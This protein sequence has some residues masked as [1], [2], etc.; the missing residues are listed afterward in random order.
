MPAS[1]HETLSMRCAFLQPL[2]AI[3]CTVFLGACAATTPGNPTPM[4]SDS[5]SP[6]PPVAA[7]KP[8]PVP[9]PN[10]SREDEYYWLRDD[11]R[12]DPEVLAYL[13]AENAY[14]DAMLAHV[15][16]LQ[17]KLYAEI[18]ARIKQDDSSVP[19]RK[20][21]YWYYRR[22]E[23]GRE[24]PLYAR[25]QGSPD[26]PEQV[27][28]DANALA[29]GHEFFAV[30]AL[31]VSPDDRYVAWAEDTVGRRQYVLRIKDLVTGEI[32][33]DRIGNTDG[34]I[35]WT[36]DGAS[37]LYIEKD[38]QTLLGWRVRRHVLGS[39]PA[40]DPLVYEQEDLSFYTGLTTTKDDRYILIVS[41][42]TLTSEV[43]FAAAADPA[44]AFRVMIPREK[45]HEYDVDHLDGRWVIRSNWEAPNFRLLEAPDGEQGDRTRWREIIGHRDDA[46]I[47][48]FDVFRDFVAVNERSEGLRKLRILGW[49]GRTDFHVASDEP[50]YAMTLGTNE[51]VETSV[52]RYVYASLTTPA[53]TYDF[54]VATGERRLMKREPV[55]GDFDPANYATEYRWATARDGTRVPVSIVY[56]RT[57]R[58]D[59][60][61]PLVVY[62]YGAYGYALD[63][64]FSLT[65]LPLLDRGFVYAIAH[66]RGGQ[67]LGR[68]WYDAGRLLA[69]KNTFTD[70]VDVTRFLVAERYGDPKRVFGRGGSAG[71]L[72]MGAVANMAPGDYRALLVHVPF[73]DAVTTMLDDSIPLTANEYDEWG[74]PAEKAFYDYILSYSHYD[75]VARQDYPALYVTTGLWD[76]QVQYFEPAKWVARLRARKTDANPL[77]FRTTLEAGHGGKSGRFEQFREIAEEY[78]FLLDQAGIRE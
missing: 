5:A 55:L 67:E 78:A 46:F 16:P 23:T 54:D 68:R 29:R 4:T 25:R 8:H 3:S 6:V 20:R 56:R 61:A 33:P 37:V 51:E 13:Q 50:A 7:A 17:E 71:G 74:N 19:Y 28:L 75:N 1:R 69:K 70:F 14:K 52:V 66:V 43:R 60:T 35:A 34:D 72:L 22:F 30:G 21:G 38:P 36:A 42:G 11:T 57:T 31:E 63:P 41:D 59:G 40:G 24:Y 77:L 47:H 9:S 32:L 26:G 12:S 10:G 48:D 18:V 76:S 27:M 45:G 53:T 65:L 62:G 49:D 2:A 15:A 44:L 39:D 58:R 73:V 64:T